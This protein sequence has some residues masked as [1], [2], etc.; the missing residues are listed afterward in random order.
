[1]KNSRLIF[2]VLALWLICCI[3]VTGVTTYVGGSPLLSAALS[4]TNEFTPGQ[5]ATIFITV[6]NS[7]LFTPLFCTVM[8]IVAS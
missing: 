7:R 2:F 1:M 6:Q 8:N 5:D 3:P 4:G